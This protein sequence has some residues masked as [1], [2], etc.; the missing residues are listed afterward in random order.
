MQRFSLNV[1]KRPE[2]NLFS[3]LSLSYTV[4]VPGSTSE[5]RLGIGRPCSR[6]PP[7]SPALVFWRTFLDLQSVDL[8]CCEIPCLFFS[9]TGSKPFMC[10]ICNFATAQLGDARNHVKRHLGMR[11]YKCHICGWVHETPG[12]ESVSLILQLNDCLMR[13]RC[14]N[15]YLKQC[16]FSAPW[17]P[18]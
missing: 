3:F 10:K 4:Y 9:F 1:I 16:C 7:A 6:D 11:E 18:K 13:L 15:T 12:L 14:F 2:H 5:H 17:T 8:Y